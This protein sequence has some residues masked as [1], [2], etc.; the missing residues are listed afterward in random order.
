M[1]L[2]GTQ[3]PPAPGGADPFGALARANAPVG[4]GIGTSSVV[5]ATNRRRRFAAQVLGDTPPRDGPFAQSAQPI[6]V[7]MP[8][9]ARREVRRSKGDPGGPNPFR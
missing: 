8:P 1:K 3:T 5:G 9:R 2:G 4:P 6:A 7:A